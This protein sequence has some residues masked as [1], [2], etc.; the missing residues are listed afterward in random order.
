MTYLMTIMFAVALMSTSCCKDDPIPDLQGVW[1]SD[2]YSLNGVTY[3]ACNSSIGEYVFIT[4]TIDDSPYSSSIADNC[5]S[6]LIN[7]TT[8]YD[9]PVTWIELSMS[10]TSFTFDVMN[11]DGETLTLLLTNTSVGDVPEGGTYVLVKN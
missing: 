5:G 1:V 9:D 7:G 10:G 6:G 4:F 2:S 3:D 11:Y 8:E